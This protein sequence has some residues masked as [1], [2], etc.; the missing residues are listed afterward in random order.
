M[1]IGEN[2]RKFRDLKGYSQQ[3]LAN[4]LQI[5]QKQ[6]S[7]IENNQ[8]SPTFDLVE[9]I[10]EKL[11][12]KLKALLEFKDEMIFNSYTENQSGGEFFAY[13]NTDIKQVELLYKQLLQEKNK[14]IILLEEKFKK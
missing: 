6:L 9:K 12:V 14:I 11:G 7:R 8:T 1:K 4:D 2:I 10:C 3:A 13:N 5:S